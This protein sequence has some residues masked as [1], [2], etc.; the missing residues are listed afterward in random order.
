[1]LIEYHLD[2]YEYGC[3]VH[4]ASSRSHFFLLYLASDARS[5]PPRL[6][7]ENLIALV[8]QHVSN[9]YIKDVALVLLIINSCLWLVITVFK[10][11]ESRKRPRPSTPDLEKPASPV[12]TKSKIDRKPGGMNDFGKPSIS[13]LLTAIY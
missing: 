8:P 2:F 12:K 3:L 11:L 1:M 6:N 5:Q 13:I 9:Y 4:P 7:M 10:K